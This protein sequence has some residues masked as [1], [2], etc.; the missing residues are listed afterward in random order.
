MRNNQPITQQEYELADNTLLVSYTDLHGNITLANEAFVEASGF[1]YDELLGQPHN[2]LRHPDVPEQVFFDLWRTIKDGRPWNQIVKNRR[3]NGD[4]YWVEANTTPIIE[5]GEIIGYMSVRRPASKEQ[6]TAAERA[7]DLIRQGKLS[8][9]FGKPQKLT[10]RLNPLPNINPPLTTIPAALLAIAVFT[11]SVVTGNIPFWLEILLVLMTTIASAH[12]L[13]FVYQIKN[14]IRSIDDIANGHLDREVNTDG[15]NFGGIVNRRIKTMQTRLS[16]ANNDFVTAAR[17]SSRLESG[18]DNLNSYIMIADQNRTITYMNPSL[19]TFLKSVEEDFRTVLP[20]FTA[21]ELIGKNIDIFHKNPQHQ[22]DILDNLTD[23]YIAK[24]EVAGHS[25]QLVMSPI[26]DSEGNKIGT[27]VE[28]Q[29]IFQEQYV[30]NSIKQLVIDANSGKLESRINV[31]ELDGFYKELG[32]DFNSLM[33]NL[34]NTLKQ[35][36]YVISGLSNRDLTL[37]PQGHFQGEY[38]TTIDNLMNGINDLRMAFCKMDGQASEVAKSAEQVKTSNEQLEKAINIQVEDM[39]TTASS[40]EE[41]TAQVNETAHKAQNSDELATQTQNMVESGSSAMQEAIQS[42]HEIESVSEQI[43]GIVSLIDGI[44]FQTNLLALNAAVEAARAGEHGRGFAVVAGEVRTLAQKSAEAAKDIKSLI[45]TTAEKISDGTQKV[46]ST[47]DILDEIIGKTREVGKNISDIALNAQEQ[48]LAVRQINDAV[49]RVEKTA[50]E[51]HDLVSE[52]A[53][54]A[55]YLGQVSESMDELV[56]QFNLG[57]C[58][59]ADDLSNAS[60][61]KALI[62]DDTLPNLKVAEAMLTKLGFGVDSAEN[63][64]Q[65]VQLARTNEYEVILM[66]LEMPVMNGL[67]ATVKIRQSGYKGP[68]YA[69]TGNS[70]KGIKE[71]I[72]SVGMNDL[73]SKPLDFSK[74]TQLLG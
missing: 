54:L 4:H 3:K 22:I 60:S 55:A 36:S 18:L 70:E 11:V 23:A 47:G 14:A 66:D 46:Q 25:L 15:E 41:I 39:H 16:A 32:Q 71:K 38:K 28:W 24:I 27:V 72:K 62:A 61:R 19:E 33:E 56:E 5:N 30:Q 59:Q 57:D 68:I 74:I 20:H 17:K 8:L 2:I 35:I 58:S 64:Q 10:S 73:L 31:S 44:A 34:Q 26:F 29:D 40:I 65:A 1:N 50:H 49:L 9:R 37:K 67:D 45:E 53:S 69:Y 6:K 51:S 63:G 21:D 52:N 12:A 43:T 13:Y 42:M 48:A 7:Y